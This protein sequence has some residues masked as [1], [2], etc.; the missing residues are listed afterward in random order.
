M[1]DGIAVWRRHPHFGSWPGQATMGFGQ[2]RWWNWLRDPM[3]PT[4]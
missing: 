1:G 2:C 4:Q 3:L